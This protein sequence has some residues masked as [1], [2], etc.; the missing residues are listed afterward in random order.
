M[1]SIKTL[2]GFPDKIFY[3]TACDMKSDFYGMDLWDQVYS[4]IIST[5][6]GDKVGQKINDPAI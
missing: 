4:A 1:L 5:Q 2:T 3:E 6:F